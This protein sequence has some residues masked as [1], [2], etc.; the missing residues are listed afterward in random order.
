MTF[1]PI[2]AARHLAAEAHSE[3]LFT[4]MIRLWLEHHQRMIDLGIRPH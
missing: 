2:A 3:S 1:H 4:R